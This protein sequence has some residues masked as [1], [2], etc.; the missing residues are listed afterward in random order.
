MELYS[1][2]QMATMLHVNE[3]T[4]RRWLRSGNLQGYRLGE[5]L[6]RVSKEQ[7]E[8]FLEFGAHTE[9]NY[10]EY[11]GRVRG[12]SGNNPHLT[13]ARLKEVKNLERR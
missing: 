7:L 13:H 8:E 11:K 10:E 1:P 12:V 4:V 5:R 9:P 2:K 6:W 3:I